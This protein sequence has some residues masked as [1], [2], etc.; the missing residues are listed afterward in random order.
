MRWLLRWMLS[1]M[2]EQHASMCSLVY[3]DTLDLKRLAGSLRS[4]MHHDA[5]HA[6]PVSHSS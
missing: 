1:C 4:S 6:S 2:S 5:I 3:N